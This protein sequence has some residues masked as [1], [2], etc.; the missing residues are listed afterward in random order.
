MPGSP[1]TIPF[2]FTFYFFLLLRFSSFL[3]ISFMFHASDPYTFV[4]TFHITFFASSL[5][6][7]LNSH[8]PSDTLSYIRDC[9]YSTSLTSRRPKN[10]CLTLSEPLR[11]MLFN[12]KAFTLVLC[13]VLHFADTSTALQAYHQSLSI[14]NP[15]SLS[16]RHM[17]TLCSGWQIHLAHLMANVQPI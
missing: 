10:L 17:A 16:S 8:V 3:L 4:H 1:L 7:L 11:P 13:C 6:L 14:S 9:V 5:N 2:S 12:S 15:T